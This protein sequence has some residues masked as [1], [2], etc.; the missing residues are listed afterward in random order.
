MKYLKCILKNSIKHKP[1]ATIFLL[2]GILL[3]VISF[4]VYLIFGINTK[5]FFMTGV[6]ITSIVALTNP[7]FKKDII[8]KM[9]SES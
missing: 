4:P 6:I 5:L 3:S 1:I 8:A 2:I 9:K 7:K